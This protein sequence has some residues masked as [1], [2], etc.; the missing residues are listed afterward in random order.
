M[1][2]IDKNDVGT[3][4]PTARRILL[5]HLPDYELFASISY[6]RDKF[7]A[8]LNVYNLTNKKYAANGSY[9][10]DL[11]EWIFDVGTPVNFRLQVSV[12]I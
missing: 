10:P 1:Y 6:D 8:G 5:E 12:R 4:D 11:Q 3:T 2:N 9:Y 7:S